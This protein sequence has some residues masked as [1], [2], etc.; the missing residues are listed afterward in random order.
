MNMRY[1]KLTPQDAWFFRDGRPYN[2]GE[3]NQ[4]DAVSQFPPSPR[5]V[6]G[7]FRAALARANGWNGRNRWN[8]AL[9]AVLGNDT[10]DLAA[11]QFHGPFIIRDDTVLW[12]VPFHLLGKVA[13]RKWTPAAF[14]RPDRGKTRTDVGY[15]HLPR[16]ASTGNAPPDDLKSPENL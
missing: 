14:L 8:S 12:P 13:K 6:T 1:F 9:N 11:L 3:D 7:A 5:T 2:Q 10:D 16:V 4:A 15:V